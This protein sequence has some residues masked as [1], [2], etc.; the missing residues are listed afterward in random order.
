LHRIGNVK[1]GVAGEPLVPLVVDVDE[2]VAS[3]IIT[4]VAQMQRDVL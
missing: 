3:P 2:H 4:A 1:V